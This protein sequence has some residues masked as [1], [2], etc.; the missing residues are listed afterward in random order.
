MAIPLSNADFDEE[1]YSMRPPSPHIVR[2]E[3]EARGDTPCFL[4]DWRYDCT[5][6]DCE[7]RRQCRRLVAE[8]RRH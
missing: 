1:V 8:W 3:Q 2:A 5:V 6:V 7:W 4:T